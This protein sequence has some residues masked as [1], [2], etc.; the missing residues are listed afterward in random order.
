[1]I[2]ISQ[3]QTQNPEI[4]P[5]TNANF[6]HTIPQRNDVM[7]SINYVFSISVRL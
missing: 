6:P 4:P 5:S 2:S 7:G 3:V 1:M